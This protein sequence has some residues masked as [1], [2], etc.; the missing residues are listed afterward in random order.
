MAGRPWWAANELLAFLLEMAALA[1]L[2][3][4]GFSLAGNPAA[5]LLLGTAV[6]AAA[7]VLWA[8]FAAPRAR[9]RPPLVGVLAV[10]AAVLGGGALALY[11]VGHPVAAAVLG[12]VVVVNTA[13]AETFRHRPAPAA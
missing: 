12:A 3:W 1:C 9:F 2:F 8:L 7:I 11:G 6:L 5:Q 10:K 4:W 13:L